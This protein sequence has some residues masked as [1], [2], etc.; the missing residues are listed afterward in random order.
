MR[1]LQRLSY[2]NENV[3]SHCAEKIEMKKTNRSLNEDYARGIPDFALSQIASDAA[4]D[5]KAHIRRH[6]QQ[7]TRDPADQRKMFGAANITIE[8]L[9]AE[10]KTLLEDKLSKFIRNA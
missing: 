6:I 3:D 4:E 2:I 5:L 7:V 9:E 10:I 8:E 1:E